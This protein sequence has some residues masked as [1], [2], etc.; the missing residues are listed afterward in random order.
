M[1]AA[2]AVSWTYLIGDVGHEGY[3][4][5][6]R[7][8]RALAPAGDAYRDATTTTT[9]DDQAGDSGAGAQFEVLKGMAT[10]AL[11]PSTSGGSVPSEYQSGPLTPWTNTPSIP[12]IED[13]RTVMAERAVFQSLASMGLP[14]LTIHSVVKYSGRLLKGSKSVFFRTWG[15]I[16]VCPSF[17]P[18]L[19]W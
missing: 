18:F 11:T 9:H 2:Y 6:L 10:G 13:Y 14:A 4:A 17:F 12:L 8:R 7:N 19:P 16:G 1:R 15:P 5:Y 3:K